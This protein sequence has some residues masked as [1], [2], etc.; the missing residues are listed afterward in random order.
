RIRLNQIKSSIKKAVIDLNLFKHY[1]SN[2]RQIRY[3]RYATRLYLILIVISV[4]SLSVYHLIRKRIQRKTIL[5]PSLSKYLEL[6]QINSIDLYCPCTSISTS[7]S[8]LISIEVHYHQLCSSYL[9]SSRWIA[10]SNSISRILGD[11]YD[12]RNHA[13]NQFQTLSM[14]CE[15]AQQIMNNSLSIFLK[16]NLFSLQVIRKN[17]LKS[18]LDSAIEDWKSSKINQFISTI[19]LIR[20]TTQGNQLMNRLNIFFQFPDDVRTILEPRIYGD[21]NCAFFASL[22]STPMEIFAYSYIL[23]IE[24]FYVGCYLIDALLLSTLECFYNK[25]CMSNI[26]IFLNSSLIQSLT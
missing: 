23:L 8:T 20:N 9:V 25:I 5:N 12:Y 22:C 2:D 26:N 16:T 3:Q 7:Y 14:F 10:Y 17:Q 24:N 4:G 19:D 11:L 15:Q 6:S 1:P 18:Q 21:C 13:G